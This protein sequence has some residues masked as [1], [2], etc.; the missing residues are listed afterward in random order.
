MNFVAIDTN[1]DLKIDLD[2]ALARVGAKG[3]LTSPPDWFTDMDTNKDGFID[4][5]EFDPGLNDQIILD[6][7]GEDVMEVTRDDEM[8]DLIQRSELKDVTTVKSFTSGFWGFRRWNL[9]AFDAKGNM[10]VKVDKWYGFGGNAKKLRDFIHALLKKGYKLTTSQLKELRRKMSIGIGNMLGT[11]AKLGGSAF[12]VYQGNLMAL[13]DFYDANP[14]DKMLTS[15]DLP[16]LNQQDE[17]EG[18]RFDQE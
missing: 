7:Q 11:M 18:V 9:Q 16:A 14:N 10:I 1:A 8:G 5:E 12:K 15:S 3:T 4:T 6:R 2:E 13:K 17:D